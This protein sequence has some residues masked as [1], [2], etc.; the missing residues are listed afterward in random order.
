MWGSEIKMA[1]DKN[2][3]PKH[4]YTIP[5]ILVGLV[6]FTALFAGLIGAVTGSSETTK[7]DISIG[8][9]NDPNRMEVTPVPEEDTSVE[10]KTE[11]EEDT[12]VKETVG[13]E[14]ARKSAKS[15]LDYQAFSRSG[16]IKQLEYEG[17]TTEEATYGVDALGADWNDQAAKSAKSYL[18][19]QAFSRTGLIE[20]LEYEGFSNEQATFGASANGY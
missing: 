10:L 19:Y 5:E 20:Q 6:L 17:Y 14:N 7:S 2:S 12:S 13:Q 1:K 11:P 8:E 9:K 4:K 15:Y 16:L 18:E 3:K